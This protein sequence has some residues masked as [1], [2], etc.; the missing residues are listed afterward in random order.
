MPRG[1]LPPTQALSNEA[2]PSFSSPSHGQ[3]AVGG[4]STPSDTVP[5]RARSQGNHTGKQSGVSQVSSGADRS[6][7]HPGSKHR[8]EAEEVLSTRGSE[9]HP[10]SVVPVRPSGGTASTN[11]VSS[12]TGK[13]SS[14][15]TTARNNS[16]S[17][18]GQ[19]CETRDQEQVRK[20]VNHGHKL[21]SAALEP[22]KQQVRRHGNNF[23]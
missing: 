21:L 17:V 5:S 8:S 1:A 7:S 3:G 20:K 6:R 10:N 23:Y 13:T 15:V 18:P 19:T 14:S 16:K 4:A 11:L 9:A 2:K 12:S 22:V